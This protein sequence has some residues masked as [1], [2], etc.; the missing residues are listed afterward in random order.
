M[1]KLE[2]PLKIEINNTGA[3]KAMAVFDGACADT[4]LDV[5][6]SAAHL[7]DALASAGCHRV[8]LRISSGGST[9]KVLTYFDTARGWW[10]VAPFDLVKS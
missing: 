5:L 1:A 8:K 7:V 9:A 4:R 3:W 10:P 2:H 6:A